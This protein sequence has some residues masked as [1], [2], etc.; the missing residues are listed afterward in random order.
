VSIWQ[1]VHSS[2]IQLSGIGHTFLNWQSNPAE[3]TV[4]IEGNR[5]KSVGG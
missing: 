2:T 3:F 5:E 1:G 4:K